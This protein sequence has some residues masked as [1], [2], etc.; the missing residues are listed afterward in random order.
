MAKSSK[1]YLTEA[2]KKA[3]PGL[4]K[5]WS[6]TATGFGWDKQVHS[7]V[8]ISAGDNGVDFQYSQ[9]VADQVHVTE[10]GLNQNAPKAAMR[11]FGNVAK[12]SIDGAVCSA[13]NNMLKASGVFK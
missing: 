2:L 6:D 3:E 8:S 5:L 12:P 9:D 10:Y 4:N 7:Q 1:E 13:L 11:E